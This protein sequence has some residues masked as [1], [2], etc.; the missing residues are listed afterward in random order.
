MFVEKTIK[1]TQ[2]KEPPKA[3]IHSIVKSNLT[4]NF[5]LNIENQFFKSTR[6]TSATG[7]T[8]ATDFIDFTRNIGV[9][10]FIEN[11]R[12]TIKKSVL[13]DITH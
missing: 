13:E 1:D 5:G 2:Q 11:T 4:R 12:L 7:S 9:I 6:S 10:E 3:N 8:G